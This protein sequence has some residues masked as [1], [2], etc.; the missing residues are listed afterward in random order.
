MR[1]VFEKKPESQ[2]QAMRL[3]PAGLPN[4]FTAMTVYLPQQ[5]VTAYVSLFCL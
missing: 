4:S 5:K 1:I 3:G 2:W